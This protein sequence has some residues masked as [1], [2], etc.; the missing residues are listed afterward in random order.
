MGVERWWPEALSSFATF[1][2]WLWIEPCEP[3]LPSRLAAL[4]SW[5]FFDLKRKAMAIV[6]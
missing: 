1:P 4:R 6:V 2:A 3:E 5:F